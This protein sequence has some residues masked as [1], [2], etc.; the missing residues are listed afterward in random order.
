MFSAMNYAA[1]ENY[2]SALVEIRRLNNKLNAYRTESG[3]DYDE[4]PFAYYLA[5]IMWEQEKKWD[6]SCID[7]KKYYELGGRGSNIEDDLLYCSYKSRRSSDLNKYKK[8]FAVQSYSKKEARQREQ[9]SEIL[10][11]VHQGW[12]PR[13][14]PNPAWHRVPVLRPQINMIRQVKTNLVN[15]DSPETKYEYITNTGVNL[16]KISVAALQKQYAGLMAKRIAARIAKQK[17]AREIGRDNENLGILA[18]VV[19][20][21]SDQADLRQWSTLPE[22]LQVSRIFVEPGN[23]KIDFSARHFDGRD[24]PIETEEV[25]LEKDKLKVIILRIS[26]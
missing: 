9:K 19:M 15:L 24:F 1:M 2:E 12:G 20:D 11:V 10:L 17:L 8:E 4:N 6:D 23:Y 21:V 22:S 13:K 16:E 5:G 25:H 26:G 18:K 14:V 7:Y 3:R